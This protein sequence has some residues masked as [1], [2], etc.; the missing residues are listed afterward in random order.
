MGLQGVSGG[1][2]AL[3]GVIGGF[4]FHPFT[5]SRSKFRAITRTVKYWGFRVIGIKTG[6]R[7]LQ[8]VAGC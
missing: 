7:G 5:P 6:Y 4:R 8:G 3:Q 2:R 1:Y